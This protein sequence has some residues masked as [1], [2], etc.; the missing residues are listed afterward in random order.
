M[1][2]KFDQCASSNYRD[3]TDTSGLYEYLFNLVGDDV[4]GFILD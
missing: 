3:V 4:V 1:N 2:H